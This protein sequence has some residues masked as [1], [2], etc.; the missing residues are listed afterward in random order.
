[1]AEGIQFVCQHCKHQIQSW[2]DGNPYWI[3]DYGKKHYAYHPNHEALARCIG[4]D[5]PYL[6]LNCGGEFLV[7]SRA[8]VQNCPKCESTAIADTFH[9]DG[10]PCP[11]CHLGTLKRDPRFWV[12]S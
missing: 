10:K 3:D 5:S 12:I 4:N 9:L 8:P 6:C 1:M 11:F 7:D 2:S